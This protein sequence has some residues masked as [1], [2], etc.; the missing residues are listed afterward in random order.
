VSLSWPER[1]SAG[2]A[3]DRLWL[4]R[5]GALR[6]IALAPAPDAPAWHAA[7]AALPAALG[8]RPPRTL[9]VVLSHHFV[10]YALLPWS[11]ALATEEAWRAYAAHRLAGVHGAPPARWALRVA[12]TAPRGPRIACAVEQALLDALA[13]TLRAAGVRPVSVQPHLMAAFNRARRRLRGASR[14]LVV[15]EAGRV[16]LA[17]IERGAWGALRARRVEDGWRDALP[18]LLARESALLGRD[19]P[20]EPL[21][22]SD[23]A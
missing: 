9:T 15:E 12:A 16:A 17:L 5:G 10:R 19:A 14:W 20:F 22:V 23:L 8:E 7:L 4:R 6:E 11:A 18:A 3:P 13:D 21:L 1:A 2:L